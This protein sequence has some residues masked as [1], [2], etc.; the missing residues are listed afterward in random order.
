MF[1]LD[2]CIVEWRLQMIAGGIA[3]PVPLDELESHLRDDV[4][5]QVRLGVGAPQAFEAAVQR[6]GHAHS[7]KLEFN[8]VGTVERKQ[9]KRVLAVI[10]ALFGMVF[11]LSMV[12]PQ[13][14]Q[15]SR[16]GVMHSPIFLLCGIILII[17]SGSAAFLGIRT[18]RDD[19]GRNWITVGLIAAWGFYATPLILAFF[20]APKT[21]P[22]GWVFCAGLAATSIL[23]FGGCLHFN[24]RLP[25]ASVHES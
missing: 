7:L 16:T 5:E 11:G 24:R 13:L 25:A 20:H 4:A 23:F 21:N 3:S 2:Q 19:R 9:M 1:N 15:W 17:V 22:M 12:L 8:K 10:A 14:G 6:L 18:I